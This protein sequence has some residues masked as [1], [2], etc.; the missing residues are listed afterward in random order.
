MAHACCVRNDCT[1]NTRSFVQRHI[2]DAAHISEH[3]RLLEA[4]RAHARGIKNA[5]LAGDM[6]PTGGAEARELLRVKATLVSKDD[7]TLQEELEAAVAKG[8]AAKAQL[9]QQGAMARGRMLHTAYPPVPL[10]P[11]TLA[12]RGAQSQTP[13]TADKS[14]N[15]DGLE[16]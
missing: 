1:H 6:A 11:E 16:A 13:D 10:G 2:A 15:E 5:C 7:C 9:R 4:Q 3:T 12:A 14:D 8:Q